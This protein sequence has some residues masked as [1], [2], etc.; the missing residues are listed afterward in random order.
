MGGTRKDFSRATKQRGRL[1]DDIPRKYFFRHMR[2]P[3][4][5][6]SYHLRESKILE[7]HHDQEKTER[8]KNK[9]TMTH[10]YLE[11]HLN[12]H[13]EGAV[14]EQSIARCDGYPSFHF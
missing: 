4:M 14:L 8:R 5:Y 7:A 12:A 1:T 13:E 11:I 9:R 3:R 2:V 10:H 6:S